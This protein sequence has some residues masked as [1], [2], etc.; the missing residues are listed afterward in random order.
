MAPNSHLGLVHHHLDPRYQGSSYHFAV[1]AVAS[2]STSPPG[3]LEIWNQWDATHYLR[4]AQ[5]GYVGAEAAASRSYF[6]LYPWLVRAA[7]FIVRNYMVRPSSLSG[8]LPSPRDYCCKSWCVSMNPKQYRAM[9]F[10]FIHLS[11]EL[12]PAHRLYGASFSRSLWVAFWPP[13]KI[14]GSLLVS[15]GAGACLTRVNGLIL[16]RRWRRRSSCNIGKRGESPALALAGGAARLPRLSLA[17][18]RGDW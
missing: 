8:L 3:W 13:A 18:P 9:L 4:L 11:H 15:L 1:Q 6:P 5:H 2:L 7:A 10:G 17:K 14:T 12:L 16:G